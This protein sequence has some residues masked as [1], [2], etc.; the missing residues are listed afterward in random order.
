M[1]YRFAAINTETYSCRLPEIQVELQK[2]HRDTERNIQLL[3]KPP[4]NN[5]CQDILNLI[6][7]FTSDLSKHLEGIPDDE[8]GLIQAILL[9]QN[10][11]QRVIKATPPT[12]R[13]YERRHFVEG[14]VEDIFDKEE[15]DRLDITNEEKGNTIFVDDVFNRAQR[16]VLHTITHLKYSTYILSGHALANSLTSI[17]LSYSSPIYRR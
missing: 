15:A 9:Q 11:F 17:H 1:T 12:F 8:E 5:P 2:L 7:N 10:C 6:S 13:P 14:F 3:P 16:Y 4:S